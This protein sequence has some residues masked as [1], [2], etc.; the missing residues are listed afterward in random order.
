[1][2]CRL[3][4][5]SRLP[6]LSLPYR[7]PDHSS[8]PL[9][10]SAI[11][12]RSPILHLHQASIMRCCALLAL[13]SMATFGTSTGEPL[14]KTRIFRNYIDGNIISYRT[15]VSTT[16]RTWSYIPTPPPFGQARRYS[17][18]PCSGFGPLAR[19][20]WQHMTA[21]SCSRHYKGRTTVYSASIHQKNKFTKPWSFL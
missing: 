11:L 21:V 8:W 18:E 15:R 12:N 2:N 17:Q 3:F 20:Q 6:T 7:P 16:Y 13:V 19:V 9:K 1:M 4:F 14:L 10:P 5:L